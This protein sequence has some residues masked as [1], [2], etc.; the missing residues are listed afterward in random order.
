MKI[1][2]IVPLLLE[3]VIK[4]DHSKSLLIFPKHYFSFRKSFK[5][6][7]LHIEALFVLQTS[8]CYDLFFL[9][10]S[11]VSFSSFIISSFSS[12]RLSFS[13]SYIFNISLINFLDCEI[14]YIESST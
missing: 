5:I 11:I 2:Q 9:K 7:K 14:S 3:V 8:F 12:I 10:S 6:L 4:Q 1:S 13:I